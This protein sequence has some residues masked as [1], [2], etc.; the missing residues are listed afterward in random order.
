MGKVSAGQ[1]G[2][3][4]NNR[5]YVS[6]AG[7]SNQ[8][9][10]DRASCQHCSS[11]DYPAHCCPGVLSR[12]SGADLPFLS[13]VCLWRGSTPLPY[14]FWYTRSVLPHSN[15]RAED[16][17]LDMD[18]WTSSLELRILEVLAKCPGGHLNNLH[19]PMVFQRGKIQIPQDDAIFCLL[20]LI[21]AKTVHMHATKATW[22]SQC[23]YWNPFIFI[24][25]WYV[26][27]MHEKY[28]LEL[29][30]FNFKWQTNLTRDIKTITLDIYC[31]FTKYLK[32][33][34][35]GLIW[36]PQNTLNSVCF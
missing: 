22:N 24:E 16:F 10:K 18:S 1:P 36:W 28:L 34:W 11:A 3:T 7:W 25:I 9:V 23:C 30:T 6:S 12:L 32:Y 13:T 19:T 26:N 15:T 5:G 2:F 8:W 35:T 27:T 20:N 31:N 4:V 21:K 14:G 17:T 33:L 29:D